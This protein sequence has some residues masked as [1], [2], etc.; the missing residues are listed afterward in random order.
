VERYPRWSEHANLHPAYNL[1]VLLEARLVEGISKN[2]EGTSQASKRAEMMDTASEAILALNQSRSATKSIDPDGI[3]QFGLVAEEVEK[4]NPDL[5]V[6]DE[7]GK[8]T[9]CAMKR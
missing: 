1:V 6:R 5:V 2:F 7:D 9:P 3:P 8:V 4:V